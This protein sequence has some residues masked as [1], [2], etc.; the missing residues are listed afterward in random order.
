MRLCVVPY[1]DRY[2]EIDPNNTDEKHD[3]VRV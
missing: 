2:A 1:T 3:R